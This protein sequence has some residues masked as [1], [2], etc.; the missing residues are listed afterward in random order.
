M[1]RAL[2]TGKSGDS[3]EKEEVSMTHGFLSVCSC[4]IP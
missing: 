3:E 4:F 2:L 1:E